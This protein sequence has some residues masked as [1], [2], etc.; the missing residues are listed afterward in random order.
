VLAAVAGGGLF[1]L[2]GCAS[3]RA[4]RDGPDGTET[5]APPTDGTPTPTPTPEDP[6]FERGPTV[7]VE[8]VA[9]GLRLPTTFAL[10]PDGRRFIGD[11]EGVVYELGTDGLASPP[12]LD[13]T[14]RVV[15][16][17]SDLPEWVAGDD[18]GLLGLAFHPDFA[19][20]GRVYVRY[21]TPLGPE[22]PPDH[23]HREILSEF[24][25]PADSATADPDSERVLL[26]ILWERPVHQAGGIVFGPDGLLY[27]AL[28]DGLNPDN[29][30][31]LTNS[32]QG[33][34][35]RI[36]VDTRTDGKPYGIPADNPLVGEDGLDEYFA[37]GLRNPWRMAF[38]PDGR[39]VAGDVGQERF[40]EVNVVERGGNYGW[41]VREGLTCYDPA[42]PREPRPECPTTSERGEPFVDPVVTF[43]HFVDDGAQPVGFAVVGGHVY[44]GSEV[45]ALEGEYLFGIYTRSLTAPSGGLVAATPQ[46]EGEWPARV[47]GIDTPGGT[48]DINVLSLGQDADG[49]LYVLGTRAG[50]DDRLGGRDGVVYRIVPA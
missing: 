37:W 14:D 25:V 17:G 27:G 19:S 33:G 8:P 31:T 42:N 50:A 35:Y 39:L 6:Y 29:G 18:R 40:E 49:E 3:P 41:P 36:D 48:L 10:A 7:G 30:Q 1:G 12:F 45:P 24:Q 38:T 43:P 4:R 26:D 2:A 32:L 44:T 15:E 47:V 13:I 23:D 9:T 22:D 34:I 16:L 21:S 28:G 11:Q 46:S 20:N 5:A